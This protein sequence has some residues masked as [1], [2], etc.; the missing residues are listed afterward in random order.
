M[1]N[2]ARMR[3]YWQRVGYRTAWRETGSLWTEDWEAGELAALREEFGVIDRL[4]RAPH[5][6]DDADIVWQPVPNA[7]GYR[8]CHVALWHPELRAEGYGRY[9]E[10]AR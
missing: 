7:L 10:R 8:G 9:V 2:S 5:V 3:R 1:S 4:E 6:A